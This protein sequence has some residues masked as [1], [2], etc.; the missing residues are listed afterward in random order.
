MAPTEG[1][2]ARPEQVNGGGAA[3]AV[4]V[5]INL[6]K[7]KNPIKHHTK[8]YRILLIKQNVIHAALLCLC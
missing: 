2:V 4:P 8:I 7:H 3:A 5:E 1:R 6:Q